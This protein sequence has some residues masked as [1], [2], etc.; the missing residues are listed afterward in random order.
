MRGYS[1]VGSAS[2]WHSEGQGFESPYLHSKSRAQF[3]ENSAR[4][5]SSL[6]QNFLC[7]MFETAGEFFLRSAV[8]I[9]VLTYYYMT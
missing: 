9:F 7:W 6:E 1:A 8:R 3:V 4:L 2:E 5:L